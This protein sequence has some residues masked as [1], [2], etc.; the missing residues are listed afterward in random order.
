M[1]TVSRVTYYESIALVVWWGL[2]RLA[3]AYTR[4]ADYWL[5]HNNRHQVELACPP[6]P[7]SGLWDRLQF[8]VTRREQRQD[9]CL[10]LYQQLCQPV[11]PSLIFDS[12]PVSRLPPI[13]Q[14][15]VIP[16]VTNKVW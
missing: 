11:G 13:F 10:V 1:L 7:S 5:G 4:E 6:S 15:S 14:H 2:N 9:V 8:R 3:L 16:I 12:D